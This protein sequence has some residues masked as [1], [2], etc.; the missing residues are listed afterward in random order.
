MD[1]RTGND[2]VASKDLTLELSRTTQSWV[3]AFIILLAQMALV[4]VIY[5]P[6]LQLAFVSDAWIYLA[7]LQTGVWATISRPM[8]YHFQPVACLW[9]ALIRACFGENPAAFQVISLVQLGV[10]G[11]ETY[12]LGRRLLP[13]VVAAFLGS[14]LVI[15]SAAFY[16]IS[17]WPLAG[18][19]QFLGAQLYVLAVIVAHDLSRGRLER[20]GPWLLALTTLAATFT[21][22]AMVTSLPVCVLTMVLAGRPPGHDPSSPDS[23]AAR[24]RAVLLLA[25]V[26]A[27]FGCTR[28]AFATEFSQGPRPG[29]DRMSA[30]W[31]LS[32]GVL[33]VFSLRGSQEVVHRLLVLGTDAEFSDGSI[34]ICV[35]GWLGAAAVGVVTCFWRTRLSGVRVL[36]AFLVTHLIALSI[37]GGM[38]SRESALPAVPAALLTAWA[39]RQV[40]EWLA[41]MVRTAPGATVCRQLPALTVLLL[42]VSAEADHLT[43]ATLHATA[44][45]LSRDLPQQVKAHAPRGKRSIHLTLINMPAS[46]ISRGMAAWVFQNGLP[47]QV[48]L[49]SP[50]VE[51]LQLYRVSVEGAPPDF[52]NG[53]VAV[54]L[55]DL[56]TQLRDASQVVLLFEIEPYGWRALTLPGLDSLVPR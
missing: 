30:Y 31:L 25:V 28:W 23:R 18:N 55:D 42:I 1:T 44:A 47:E 40:A 39:L 14:L 19:M 36:L 16:E 48:R 43:A 53:S 54:S 35:V 46:V 29:F 27:L 52:A 10:L 12:A 17:Y 41:S 34:W 51:T 3:A 37:A 38:A 5:R 2:Y 26:A 24:I 32:R 21:H 13:D 50:E 22:P 8:G 33:A 45:H 20:S 4:A 15:G 7:Q 6:T 11:Y 9:I 56:R 49:T